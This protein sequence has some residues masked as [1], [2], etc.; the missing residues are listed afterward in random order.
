L[1]TEASRVLNLEAPDSVAEGTAE[2]TLL[3]S[4][5][6]TTSGVKSFEDSA[7]SSPSARQPDHD[8]SGC[9]VVACTHNDCNSTELSDRT[10]EIRVILDA[11]WVI[12][13]FPFIN[14]SFLDST[15]LL[16]QEV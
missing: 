5:N 9:Q 11:F 16:C 2:E 6:R 14:N 1:G 12:R 3:E 4:C 13:L 15:D 8:V 10:V 7:N